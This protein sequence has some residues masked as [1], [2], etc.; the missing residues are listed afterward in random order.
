[1]DSARRPLQTPTPSL[2]FP[3][4]PGGPRPL[5]EPSWSQAG[6]SPPRLSATPQTWVQCLLSHSNASNEG[7]CRRPRCGQAGHWEG[8]CPLSPVL[9]LTGERRASQGRRDPVSPLRVSDRVS[10]RGCVR[11]SSFLSVT[12]LPPAQRALRHQEHIYFQSETIS[13]RERTISEKISEFRS[14]PD[15]VLLCFFLAPPSPAPPPRHPHHPLQGSRPWTW[16]SCVCNVQPRGKEV[17]EV[18]TP[19]LYIGG[20]KGLFLGNIVSCRNTW[21]DFFCSCLCTSPQKNK[22]KQK[23]HTSPPAPQDAG[24]ACT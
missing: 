10:D 22:T 6:T 9:T 8:S 5:V 14:Q 7:P 16:R 11:T 3:Q 2:S 21:E 18:Q 19:L 13:P 1:M 17:F 4:Q 24:Q 12:C 20:R 15:K 23:N